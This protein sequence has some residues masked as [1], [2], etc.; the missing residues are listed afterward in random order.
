MNRQFF[1]GI[2]AAFGT[3]MAIQDWYGLDGYVQM[4]RDNWIDL[5]WWVGFAVAVLATLLGRDKTPNG[6][7]KPTA[8]NEMD[9]GENT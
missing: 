9:E 4:V 8:A 7:G 6:Q 2:L 5:P 3:M 1:M